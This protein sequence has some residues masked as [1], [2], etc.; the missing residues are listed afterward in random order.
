MP[1]TPV[2]GKFG[3]AKAFF[4]VDGFN[5]LA[6]K[7]QSLSWKIKAAT[8]P[9]GGL[10]D[11]WP[12]HSPTGQQSA[13][14]AQGGGFFDTSA[15]N[16]HAALAGS[17]PSS[18]TD[19][20]RVATLGLGGNTIGQP[21]M[22]FEGV[23]S[24]EYEV[25]SERDKLQ[26]ANAAYTINGKAE[27]GV[28]LHALTTESADATTEPASSLDNSTLPQRA[29]PIVSSSVAVASVITTSVPHGLVTGDSVVI[30]GHS[31][32]TPT[33][34]G[35]RVATVLTPTTFSIPVNVSIGGTG[36]SFTRA[37]TNN[38]GAGY[39]EVTALTL[40]T[41]TD[42]LV[43][44]RHSADDTTYVDLLAFTAVTATRAAERKVVAPGTAVNRY[45][46]QNVDFRGAGAGG[47]ITYMTGFARA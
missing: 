5:M 40:G 4:L 37:K 46:A 35:E 13:E 41:F 1:V 18:P 34:N 15:G 47:S 21:F 14:L 25:L 24:H 31:G 9:T 6:A 26:R 28:I 45:L 36:G 39:L 22:G 7:L 16:S 27:E 19:P 20:V 2:A 32:S 29:V 8:E 42:A 11:S 38:G 12:E 17:V 3:S 23:Y 10:G 44:I 43:T 30:A 33:I